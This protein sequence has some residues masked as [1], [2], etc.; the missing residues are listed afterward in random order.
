MPPVLIQKVIE[1]GYAQYGMKLISQL[2]CK[3]FSE[4]LCINSVLSIVCELNL[5][6]QKGA[7]PPLL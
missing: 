3:S 5:E 4:S 7:K 2:G 1:Y 6:I